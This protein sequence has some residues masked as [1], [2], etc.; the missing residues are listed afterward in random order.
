MARVS[1][2]RVT[3]VVLIEDHPVMRA[4]VRSVLEHVSDIEVIGEADT[5][6]QGIAVVNQL[7]PDVVLLDIGLPGMDGIK[8][9]QVIRSSGN[10]KVIIFSCQGGGP[11]VS[12][13][14]ESGANG[15]LTKSAKPREIVDAV[16]NVMSNQAPLSAEASTG[17][18]AALRA[19][20][21]PGVDSLTDRERQVWSSLAHG[22]SN[23]E[24][25]HAL[26]ISEH[27]VKFHVHNLLRKLDLHSR[28]EAICAAHRRGICN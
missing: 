3:R 23:A 7:V 12:L 17:L 9:L 22:L 20:T 13:A 10:S 15:Y 8:T 11:S 24:I 26:F 18:I 19:R 14:M 6:E 21:E 28:A 5:G 27:T 2:M 1:D 25:A 4:G 16:R